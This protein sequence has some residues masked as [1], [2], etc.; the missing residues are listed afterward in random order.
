M[1]LLESTTY[2]RGIGVAMMIGLL[3]G[4]GGT[5]ALA[6]AVKPKPC[7]KGFIRNKAKKC[8]RKV[9]PTT[10]KKA[11]TTTAKPSSTGA[12]SGSKG[13]IKLGVIADEINARGQV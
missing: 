1:R 2:R 8:V 3:F 6:K 11:V 7:K 10:A 4:L 9:A 13:T 12:A 5:E